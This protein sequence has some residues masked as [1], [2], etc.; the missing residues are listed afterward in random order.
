[1]RMSLASGLANLQCDGRHVASGCG[2]DR[3][4]CQITN[5]PKK[6]PHRLGLLSY[7]SAS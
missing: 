7:P 4:E 3:V 1:M 5:R 2:I 6:T